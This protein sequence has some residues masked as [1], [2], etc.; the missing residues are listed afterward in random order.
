MAR[1]TVVFRSAP[2]QRAAVFSDSTLRSWVIGPVMALVP[3][4]TDG[5]GRRPSE[6]RAR[7]GC[8]GADEV[9]GVPAGLPGCWGG[10]R[11]EPGLVCAVGCFGL[12][13][14]RGCWPGGLSGQEQDSQEGTRSGDTRGDEAADS[15]AAQEG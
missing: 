6:S 8:A 9:G 5:V 1:M 3:F 15:Q 12:V 4:G 2:G 10:T 14:R 11:L 7:R 13:G